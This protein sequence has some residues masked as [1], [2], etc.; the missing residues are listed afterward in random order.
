MNKPSMRLF[1]GNPIDVGVVGLQIVF[2]RGGSF[3]WRSARRRC[4]PL[5]VRFAGQTTPVRRTGYST[6]A[7]NGAMRYPAHDKPMAADD[8]QPSFH[9][10]LQGKQPAA[11]LSHRQLATC[12][13]LSRRGGSCLQRAAAHCRGTPRRC[14]VW[15]T[16]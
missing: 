10:L 4:R 3:T 2:D 1:N 15:P 7:F 5:Q 11:G 8:E 12:A 16:S 9:C 6:H 14:S 13:G